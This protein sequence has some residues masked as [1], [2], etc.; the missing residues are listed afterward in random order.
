MPHPIVPTHLKVLRGN[1]GKQKLPRNEMKPHIESE[2]PDPPSHVT[3]SAREE[4]FRVG[5][6]LHRLRC[7]TVMDYAG[8]GAYCTAYQKWAEIE[9]MLNEIR[10]GNPKKRA[11]FMTARDGGVKL[12]P[13][14]RASLGAAAEMVRIA[15]EFGFSPA[16][17]ARIAMGIDRAEDF[18][19]FNGLI[20]S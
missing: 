4:W 3:G 12:N 10:S 5:T 9:D 14:L 17:R 2:I 18:G 11:T 15:G 16:A 7:L 19:K 8:L 1:P 13:L 20:A 6:E